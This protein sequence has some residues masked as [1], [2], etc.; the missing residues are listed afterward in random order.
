MQTQH[1]QQVPP[2]LTVH[3]AARIMKVT[4]ATVYAWVRA[5]EFPHVR[6]GGRIRIPTAKVADLLGI[7]SGEIVDGLR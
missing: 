2:T 3:E 1:T 5:D 4:P 7:T 6:L